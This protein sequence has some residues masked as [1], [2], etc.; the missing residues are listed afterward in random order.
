MLATRA[1]QPQNRI[2]GAIVL[3]SDGLQGIIEILDSPGSHE[4]ERYT[5]LVPHK[6]NFI[7]N[8]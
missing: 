4:I 1:W 7:A 2:N 8:R 3:T 5:F 6:P